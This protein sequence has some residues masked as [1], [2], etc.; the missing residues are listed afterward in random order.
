MY[1]DD[2]GCVGFGWGGVDDKGGMGVVM[3]SL[4]KWEP[5]QATHAVREEQ[6]FGDGDKVSDKL[7]LTLCI[8][9]HMCW[10]EYSIL[11]GLHS[12]VCQNGLLHLSPF[13]INL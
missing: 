1:T 6:G 11:H 12:L 10:A 8:R 9:T 2:M 13:I 4:L 3:C 5:C 7:L